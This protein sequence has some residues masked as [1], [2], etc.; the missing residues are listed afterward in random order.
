MTAQQQKL[1]GLV[2]WAEVDYEAPQEAREFWVVGTGWKATIE[3]TCQYIATVQDGLLVWHIYE[4]LA[5]PPRHK[6]H[7]PKDGGVSNA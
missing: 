5:E 3:P 4:K 6:G 7:L 2:L 1:N